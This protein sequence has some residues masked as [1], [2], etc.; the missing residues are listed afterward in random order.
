MQRCYNSA[1]RMPK[2]PWLCCYGAPGCTAAPLSQ[3]S[4]N[5]ELP[6]ST[7][8]DP[9]Q[10]SSSVPQSKRLKVTVSSDACL[11][12]LYLLLRALYAGG[13][14]VSVSVQA[15]PSKP[16]VLLLSDT[17]E[18]SGCSTMTCPCTEWRICLDAR[19]LLLRS[20]TPS[21]KQSGSY[22]CCPEGPC[23]TLCMDP[24]AYEEPKQGCLGKLQEGRQ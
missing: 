7:G 24:T 4:G 6:Q 20:T 22:N 2:E 14:D 13:F 12:D 1:V 9:K 18:L 21:S 3:E 5:S 17:Q 8:L 16:L 15:T 23:K 10:E 11:Q 19:S